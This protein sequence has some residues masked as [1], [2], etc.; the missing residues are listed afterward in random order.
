MNA[1]H[2]HDPSVRPGDPRTRRGVLLLVVLSMLT[3]FM[4]LGVAYVI[5]ASRARESSRAFSRAITQER[6]SDGADLEYLDKA[7]MLVLRGHRPGGQQPTN[8]NGSTLTFAPA[9][10]SLLE[11]LYGKDDILESFTTSP[12]SGHGVLCEVRIEPPLSLTNGPNPTNPIELAGR[13]VS[14]LPEKGRM[15]SHR[16]VLA[17]PGKDGGF[18]LWLANHGDVF[19]KK[20]AA[21][22]YD[23][24][25]PATRVIINGRGHGG[26]A[27]ATN[28]S[29]DGYDFAAN[30][31][32]A[33]V[34]PDPRVPSSSIVNRFSMFDAASI[35]PNADLDKDGTAD[36][37]D[38]DGDGVL[39]GQFFHPGFAPIPVGNGNYLQVDLSCLIVDLDGRLNLNA[40]GSLAAVLYPPQH[41]GWPS[42]GGQ[43]GGAG[44]QWAT[45][46][47][48]LGYGPAEIDPRIAFDELSLDNGL[49]TSEEDW[50]AILCGANTAWQY[51]ARGG[52]QGNPVPDRNCRTVPPG[53]AALEGRYGGRARTETI[54][55]DSGS[56]VSEYD[57]DFEALPGLEGVND[58][59]SACNEVHYAG[60]PIDLH[61]R[62]KLSAS[63]STTGSG[64]PAG[65]VPTMQFAQPDVN[66]AV[67]TALDDD[68]TDDPYEI[69]LVAPVAGGRNADPRT[70]GDRYLAKPA[71]GQAVLPD[72][73]FSLGE[74]ERVLRPYD[75][76]ATERPQRLF[77][78]LGS[79][80][81][82]A[83][84]LVTTESWC[85]PAITGEAAE[86]LFGPKS[87]LAGVDPLKL[88]ATVGSTGS[89]GGVPDGLVPVDLAA[90]LKLAI[91]PVL[92]TDAQRRALFKDLYMTC[93]ALLEKAGQNPSPQAAERYAQWA[94]NVVEFQDLD[95]TMTR[96]EYDP[97][98]AD[99]WDVDGDPATTDESP[100]AVVWGGERPDVI[101]TQTLAWTNSSQ[102]NDGE[103]YVM[104]HRPLK[105]TIS[106]VG[107]Q[108]EAAE[109][110]DPAL[111]GAQPD[112]IDL[113]R[114]APEGEPIWRLRLGS[115]QGDKVVRF[116]PLPSTNQ[117][118]LGSDSP[119]L[120]V[121][122]FAAH[123][124]LCVRPS[125]ASSEGIT[126]PAS[127]E[128]E[129]FRVDS[130][131]LLVPAGT[132]EIR[133]E[134]LANPGLA[135]EPDEERPTYNPYIVVD[136]AAVTVVD[137]NALPPATPAPHQVS[138]RDGWAS[139]FVP[140][141]VSGNAPPE[142]TARWD[143]NPAWLVWPDRPLVGIT[144]LL[145]VPGFA[146]NS[147]KPQPS[148]EP[149]AAG[150]LR[151]Y[152]PPERN[153]YLPDPRILE[154]VRV[155]S[156]FAGTRLSFATAD[157]LDARSALEIIGVYETL[158][159]TNQ[160]DLA[161][162]PGLVNLNTI[163]SDAVWKA[164]VQGGLGG[165]GQAGQPQGVKD[166]GTADF[167][168]TPAETMGDLLSLR[169]G[170]ASDPPYEDI[171]AEISDVSL[172]PW[173]RLHTATRL[174]NTATNRSHVFG[175]WLTV[176]TVEKVGGVNGPSDLD[177]V[178]YSRMFVIYDRSKPVGF[179]PGRNHNVANGVLLKR[180][181]P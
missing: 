27:P 23:Y 164:V 113:G 149:N 103:L 129:S 155:P 17:A 132:T 74:L 62:L 34:A 172:N 33:D 100:R 144:E 147:Y 136:V 24:P 145:F 37:C 161:R 9:F 38:N 123:Q 99:G 58:P 118:D 45:M 116:D 90:G 19:P 36:F 163:S 152:L 32:L 60:R 16:I 5:M 95:S 8:L 112:Q 12:V 139:R 84:L 21:G 120:E 106:F 75:A 157:D 115:G 170:N 39:D 68:L 86:L 53:L 93:V 92:Q 6:L 18:A 72:N 148:T 128:V 66:Q 151:N 89:S 159:P 1:C 126:V 169:G 47:L 54:D 22:A 110:I 168:A 101:I 108:P 82:A 64:P 13:I 153:L 30:P 104:L 76:D 154:V 61:G 94:A 125:G 4:M 3:L 28:E 171:A 40:H 42:G 156:R 122:G 46:P 55:P 96:Y 107:Q 150:L 105:S 98:P 117:D 130:G 97:E 181:L 85:V 180:V 137:R 25:L 50:L 167:T 79:Q 179:E 114:V 143:G 49:P 7:L 173:H 177:T 133:L 109:P 178:K 176:R 111:R 165:G 20:A 77:T 124:W 59:L 69:N 78:L 29:W 146:P 158:R 67:A 121:K 44:S 166:R 48:G 35:T 160:I 52:K 26:V 11:D 63:A 141:E 175:I 43:G 174:A 134:R 91:T 41:P 119:P 135:H 80:A 73:R 87:W 56:T 83:R 51:R 14:F 140:R 31:F 138:T 162:E 65:V 15:T 102:P 70:G 88:Y 10:E 131:A 71:A 2:S 57:V 142:M 127:P 81:E